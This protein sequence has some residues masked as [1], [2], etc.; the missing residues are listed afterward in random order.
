VEKL[1]SYKC[2]QQYPSDR[3][4]EFLHACFFDALN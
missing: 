4:K 3:F 1:D 2:N